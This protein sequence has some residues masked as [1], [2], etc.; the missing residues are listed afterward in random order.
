MYKADKTIYFY[1]F[2]LFLFFI[3]TTLFFATTHI[4]SYG[5]LGLYTLELFKPV[6][7]MRL[8]IMA[9]LLSLESFLFF[10]QFGLCLIYLIPFTLL[11]VHA[12]Q[13]VYGNR[14]YSL[15]LLS[16][17]ILIQSFGIEYGLLGIKP[18]VGYTNVKIIA[19][20]ILTW[21]ISLKFYT[22]D[23]PGNRL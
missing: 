12:K 19:N 11:I 17:F 20:I 22:Q 15:L 2:V 1:F 4:Y 8:S 23:N 16:L 18:V 21:I 3:D 5:L 13:F 7:I 9:L 6:N 10:G 14:L